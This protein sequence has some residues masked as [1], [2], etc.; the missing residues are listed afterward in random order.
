[1]NRLD[2]SADLP[3]RYAQLAQSVTLDFARSVFDST[4]EYYARLMG[5]ALEFN[6]RLADAFVPPA[7]AAVAV[8]GATALPAFAAPAPAPAPGV[9]VLEFSTRGPGAQTREFVIANRQQRD[10]PVKFEV[11]EFISE[12]SHTRR[13]TP[14]MFEPAEFV[15]SPGCERVVAC[16]LPGN[17][18]FI[19][20]E[21]QIALARV[22]GFPDMML[23]LVVNADVAQPQTV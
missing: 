20:D 13:Q 22:V 10:V 21:T 19:P 2:H 15:L 8:T 9:T 23:R 3:L 11:S 5:A 16:S 7:S 4:A 17:E 12:N 1:M 14:V 18:A 6:R